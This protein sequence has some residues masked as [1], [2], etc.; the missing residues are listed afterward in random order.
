MPRSMKYNLSNNIEKQQA[1]AKFKKLLDEGKKVELKE[2]RPKRTLSQ[3][4]YLHICITLYA[5]EFG[6]TV[7]E[8]KKELKKL[9]PFMRY[10]KEN[11]KTGKKVAF[12]KET[13]LM[14]KKEL[15]DFV[16]WIRTF[17][18]QQGCYIPTPDEY[19]EGSEKID[20]II[21]SHKE[22]L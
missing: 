5:I 20:N 1:I 12:L 21:E 17:S 10:E 7:A 22:Y 2:I 18:A 16:E 4:A 8:A 6:W 14:D 9:C 3:N 13:S 11:K 15:T 19:R